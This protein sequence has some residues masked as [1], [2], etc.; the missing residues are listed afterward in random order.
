LDIY[1]AAMEIRFRIRSTNID[2]TYGV[3]E[4]EKLRGPRA[5][6]TFEMKTNRAL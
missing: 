4:C 5:G 3:S 1:Y 6:F 2:R